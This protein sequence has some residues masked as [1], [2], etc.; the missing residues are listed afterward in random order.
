[1]LAFF[2]CVGVECDLKV[3]YCAPSCQS[4]PQLPRQEHPLGPMTVLHPLILK[5]CNTITPATRS[6]RG[7][8]VGH[9]GEI[10]IT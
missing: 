2:T 4:V 1:M 7:G 6:V 3:L 10:L 5:G 9:F 8:Y